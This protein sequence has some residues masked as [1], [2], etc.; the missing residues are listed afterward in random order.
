MF[1]SKLYRLYYGK[2]CKNWLT[3]S[4]MA[5]IQI[6]LK[7]SKFVHKLVGEDRHTAIMIK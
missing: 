1:V 6:Y 2:V 7:I 4:V 5:F 3:Y